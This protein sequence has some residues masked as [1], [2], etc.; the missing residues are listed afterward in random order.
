MRKWYVSDGDETFGP[1]SEREI[2]GGLRSG[3][4]E[5]TCSGARR[6]LLA[7]CC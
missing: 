4:S 1:F 5:P 6:L 2:Q 7:Q 3:E